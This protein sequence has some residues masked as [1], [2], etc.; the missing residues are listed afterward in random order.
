MKFKDLL[1]K[2][3]GKIKVSRIF[4]NKRNGQM[5]II[6]PKKKMKTVPTKLEIS[7]W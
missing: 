1:N 6:L 4:I 3:V 2:P 7:Y 5:T